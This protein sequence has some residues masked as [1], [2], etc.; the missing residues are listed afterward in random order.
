MIVLLILLGIILKAL[1]FIPIY[2]LCRRNFDDPIFCGIFSYLLTLVLIIGEFGLLSFFY[3]LC[4]IVFVIVSMF[5]SFALGF[6][7]WKKY[8]KTDALPWTDQA[9]S[10]FRSKSF[11]VSVGIIIIIFTALSVRSLYYYDT[12][13]DAF[14][15]GM[16]KLGHMLQHHS[17]FV[18]Y[19]SATINTFSNE[20]LGEMNALYY[21]LLTGQDRAAG[22]GNV[23][24]WLFLFWIFLWIPHSIGVDRKYVGSIALFAS[25]ASVVLGLAMTIKTDLIAMGLLPFA[26]MACYAYYRDRE[27]RYLFSALVVLLALGA[28]KITV[29]PAAGLAGLLILFVAFQKSNNNRPHTFKLILNV[30]PI[31]LILCSRYIA[32]F[33]TYGNPVQ[34][35]LNEKASFS[36]SHLWATLMGVVKGFLETPNLIKT[37]NIPAH[38][39]V[40]TKGLGYAGYPAAF[41][42]LIAI[43]IFFY[44]IIQKNRRMKNKIEI[45]LSIAPFVLGF[46]FTAMSTVWQEWSFRYFAPYILI[47]ILL[48]CAYLALWLH[49]KGFRDAALLSISA[50]L[51]ISVLNGFA[52]FRQGQAIPLP[53]KEEKKLSLLERKLLYS[54]IVKYSE[55]SAIP[56]LLQIFHSQGTA[57]VL[58]GFSMPYY[59]FFGVN[60]NVHVDIAYDSDALISKVSQKNYDIVAITVSNYDSLNFANVEESLKNLNYNRYVTQGGAKKRRQAEEG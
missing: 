33:F 57:L 5:S 31:A 36:L 45:I 46:L 55:L 40:L 53:L 32:N 52:A 26:A 35:A 17:V 2:F 21:M 23:E 47:V 12:T 39:W 1:L 27:L 38:N 34:R 20:N 50:L 37:I 6:I 16:P 15:Q 60:G 22:F 25:T 59:H 30:L 13:D 24:I 58:E 41:T 3:L 4:P 49:S 29:L 42:F 43:V 18:S 8:K 19:P 11:Y 7:C 54:S 14:V 48:G 56:N 28:S 51:I 44:M 10:L 9:K